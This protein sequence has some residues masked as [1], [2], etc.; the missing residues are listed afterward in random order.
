MRPS[1]LILGFVHCDLSLCS[2]ECVSIDNR[3]NGNREPLTLISDP[4]S[5]PGIFQ[6]LRAAPLVIIGLDPLIM[7]PRQRA[8]VVCLVLEDSRNC[9]DTP[10]PIGACLSSRD[11]ITVGL[12]RHTLIAE[13][14]R[15]LEHPSPTR[16]QAK[17]SLHQGGLFSDHFDVAL[18]VAGGRDIAISQRA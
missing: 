6:V 3:R 16:I 14:L 9:R 7:I 18:P 12:G 4:S 17:D 11:T 10:D 15:D 1:T 2:S 13:L 8:C 5:S